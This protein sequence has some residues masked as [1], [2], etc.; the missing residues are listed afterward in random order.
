MEI[1]HLVTLAQLQNISQRCRHYKC[2]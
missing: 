2:T 1:T